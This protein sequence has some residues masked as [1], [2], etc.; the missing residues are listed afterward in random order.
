MRWRRPGKKVQF[1]ALEHVD[2]SP[3]STLGYFPSNAL[4]SLP[5]LACIMGLTSPR[6]HTHFSLA[7][8]FHVPYQKKKTKTYVSCASILFNFIILKLYFFFLNLEMG[9]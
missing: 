7:L 5:N 6:I 8:M 1:Q 4:V 2:L 9:E 3:M